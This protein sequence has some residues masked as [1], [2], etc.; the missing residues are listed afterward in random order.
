MSEVIDNANKP[1]DR[2]GDDLRKQTTEGRFAAL[3]LGDQWSILP[4]VGPFVA[5]GETMP[6][7]GRWLRVDH[8]HANGGVECTLVEEPPAPIIEAPPAL[9]A[10]PLPAPILLSGEMAAEDKALKIAAARSQG[11]TGDMCSNCGAFAMKQ[12]GHCL[13]CDA[14]GTTTGCS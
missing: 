4:Y 11:Y 8:V 10:D 2:Q 9:P 6:W 5:Q 1:K 13:C 12:A 7:R 14:C 3:K